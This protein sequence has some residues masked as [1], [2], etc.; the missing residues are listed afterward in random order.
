[1][2][3]QLCNFTPVRVFEKF[4]NDIT[5]DYIVEQAILYSRITEKNFSDM[6]RN[7]NFFRIFYL[8]GYQKL[9][10]EIMYWNTD[11]DLGV[12]I[13]ASAMYLNRYSQIKQNIHLTNN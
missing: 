2:I 1:M 8:L 9:P 11:E 3:K 10:Q 12:G 13:V 4:S 5:V 6:R 7:K